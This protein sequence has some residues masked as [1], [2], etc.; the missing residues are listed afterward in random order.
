MQPNTTPTALFNPLLTAFHFPYQ[1]ED[2]GS[3]DDH[4]IPPY[5]SAI[6]PKFLA[7]KI[8]SALADQ[9]YQIR[10]QKTNYQADKEA[11]LK[12]IYL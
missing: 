12:E 11:I 2:T 7:D 1:N 9:I 5:D 3:Q 6:F 4:V 10:G 8:A